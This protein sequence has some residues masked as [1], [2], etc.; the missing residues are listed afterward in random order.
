MERKFQEWLVKIIQTS[1]PSLQP[2]SHAV[3]LHILDT[4]PM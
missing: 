4:L 3:A 1:D 2:N